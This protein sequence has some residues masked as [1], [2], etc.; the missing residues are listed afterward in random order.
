[1]TCY[2]CKSPISIT[3]RIG[4]RETCSHCGGDLHICKNCSF[5]DPK[6][7]NECREPQAERVLEKETS[8]FCDYFAVLEGSVGGAVKD[9]A[10]EA[11]K[12][13]EEMFKK[14]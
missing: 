1:M 6:S 12:K 13:L 2:F 5:Y 7:Y 10:A 8:N 4:R 9:P 3:G 11:K 14:R